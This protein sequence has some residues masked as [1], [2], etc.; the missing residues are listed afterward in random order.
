MVRVEVTVTV[1]VA[2][3]VGSGEGRDTRP[4]LRREGHKPLYEEGGTHAL[5]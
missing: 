2:V 5:T 4:Y 3:R 1:M